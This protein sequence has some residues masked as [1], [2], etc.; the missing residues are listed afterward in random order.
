MNRKILECVPNFSEGRD[1]LII[2]QIAESIRQV[3][4]VSL[5]DIDPGKA[6]NRTVM[7]FVGDPDSVVE[8]AFQ[9]IKKAAQ[10]IDMSRH[11]GAHPR[12]GAT[13]V[14]PLIP[15]SGISM[16]EAVVYAHK[17][18]SRVGEELKIPVYCY[19]AAALSPERVN[20]A[21]IRNGEYEALRSKLEKPEWKP[22]FGPAE[23]NP[24]AGATVIGARNFL[25]AYNINLNTTSER[26]ANAVAFDVRE[27]GRIMREGHPTLGKIVL[28]EHGQPRRI[29]GKCKGVKGIGWYIDEYKIAQVSMNI[30]DIQASPLH[31]VFEACVESAHARGMRVTGSELI[32][33]VPLQVLLD[34]GAWF[35][36]KQGRSQG[37]SEEELIHMAVKSMGLDELAPFDPNLKIIE[38]RLRNLEDERLIRLSVKDFARETASESPAPGGGSVSATMGTLGAA[39]STMVANLSAAKRGWEDRLGF[40]S[41]KAQEGQKIMAELLRLVD[42]DTKAFN[43]ILEA[44]R[45]PKA[46]EEE[47]KWR[48]ESL[49]KATKYAIEVPLNILRQSVRVLELALEMVKE[50]N[51]NSIS[52]A[53]VAALAGR[54]AAYGSYFNVLI[55]L[56][57]INEDPW[58]KEIKQTAESLLEKALSI[59]QEV[60]QYVLKQW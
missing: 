19:E 57:G 1:R 45:L 39:L 52:D 48:S 40:F 7:T 3:D 37:V 20:L 21:Y 59:E 55:N 36:Q 32:G 47:K 53:A 29:P 35:L 16:E 54:S 10:C 17:L 2:D 4:G 43:G 18:A 34:A 6:T 14:C 22:D 23:F 8:A 56:K 50:G 49:E 60:I 26:R 15:V 51:P 13:D 25:I 44:V 11:K 38:Y 41:L 46:T 9:A 28:D 31:Q 5:L 58:T 33:L 24:S 12:M 30:T 27:Q 42:E